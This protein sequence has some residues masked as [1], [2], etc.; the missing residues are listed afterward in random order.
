MRQLSVDTICGLALAGFAIVLYFYLIPNFV[1]E[2]E[3]ES[4]MSPQFFP[5][6]GAILIFVGGTFLALASFWSAKSFTASEGTA[7]HATMP[8]NALLVAAAMAGFVFL[9]Q[10]AGYFVATPAL[11]AALILIFG[12]RNPLIIV[13]V[14]A[15]TTAVLYLLFNFALNLPLS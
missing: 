13:L 3:F 7:E 2:V 12:G 6:L 8:L 10:V 9:F 5:Q 15:V 11:I 4:E 1:T 14:P